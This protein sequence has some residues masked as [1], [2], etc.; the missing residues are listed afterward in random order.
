MC[1][2]SCHI[3]SNI[4][5]V[6][7]DRS[8][9]PS[10]ID[11]DLT[12]YIH[13]LFIYFF[14]INAFTMADPFSIIAGSA[15]LL[16]ILF[17]IG[18]YLKNVQAGASKVEGDIS[19][20]LHQVEVL[21]AVNESIK[22]VIAAEVPHSNNATSPNPTD[23]SHVSPASVPES[24]V[25]TN[26]AARS[27][28]LRRDICSILVDCRDVVEKLENLVKEILGKEGPKVLSK[29]DGFKKQLRKQSKDEEF[30]HLRHKMTT[31]QDALQVMLTALNL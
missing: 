10:T 27:E 4:N 24:N 1:L 30:R 9:P 21:I 31:Y 3:H 22:R 13:E 2:T 20:L 6:H 25:S 11:V 23:S 15:G 5:I 18:S 19:E 16:D 14:E 28:A 12:P 8:V 7:F 17:R 29:L 26:D